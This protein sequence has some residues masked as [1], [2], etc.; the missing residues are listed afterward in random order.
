MQYILERL[1][2]LVSYAN[3]CFDHR[4]IISIYY[5]IIDRDILSPVSCQVS[6]GQHCQ[7][8]KWS[9]LVGIAEKD[10]LLNLPRSLGDA[11]SQPQNRI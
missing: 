3:C 10:E 11:K 7:E 2:R 6:T 1:L 5:T 8:E 9:L 4:M